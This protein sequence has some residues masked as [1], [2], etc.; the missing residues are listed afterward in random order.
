[1][2]GISIIYEDVLGINVEMNKVFMIHI[3][4]WSWDRL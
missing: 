2:V 1:M 4:S 3:W